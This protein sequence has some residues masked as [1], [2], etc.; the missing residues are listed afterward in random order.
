MIQ[1]PLRQYS[2]RERE[3]LLRDN[4]Q[5]SEIVKTYLFD[6]STSH[7]KLDAIVL[8][9][10]S[11][12]S[13][14][15]Q[16]MGV[17]HYLGLKGD[18]KGLFANNTLN[19]AIEILNSASDDFDDIV[20]LI[21]DFEDNDNK[22]I[23]ELLD[24]T[25]QSTK[26]INLKQLHRR[27]EE[28]DN[29]ETRQRNSSGRKEQT[30]LRKLMIGDQKE[31]QCALCHKILP[32]NLIVTAHIIPRNKCSLE[33]RKDPNIVMPACKIG[34]DSFFEEGYLEVHYDGSIQVS[35]TLRFS[36]ELKESLKPYLG[37]DCLAFNEHTKS[38]FSQKL[39]IVKV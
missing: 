13:K 14:G 35:E 15:Y 19:E 5:I 3:Y 9:L 11:S 1:L 6:S 36:E 26:L 21:S 8:G 20:D 18:F 29:T 34:C 22:V 12:E 7:R 4:Q 16:S 32:T 38:Y 17:L 30:I 23:S 28:L 27:L 33:Q 37:K 2:G 39:V 10:D 31:I 24:K 25:K